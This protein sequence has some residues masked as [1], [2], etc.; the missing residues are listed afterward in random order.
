[1]QIRSTQLLLNQGVLRQT[2]LPLDLAIQGEGFFAVKLPDGRTA[3]TRDGQFSR[4][5]KGQIVN[6]SGYQLVWQGKLPAE[7]VVI[8]VNPD[9]SVAAQQNGGWNIV[10]NI[11]VTHFSNTSGL[12]SFGQ[13]LFL[14]TP[15]S[16]AAIT[17]KAGANGNGEIYGSALEASNVNL[18]YETTHLMSLQRSFQMSLNSFQSTD[19]MLSEAIHVRR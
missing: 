11:P 14:E 6:A 19:Q 7:D 4:D 8:H 2:S 5:A 18:A 3:Y 17:G 16:G 1:V 10:G 9:G 12:N 15:V 13:N